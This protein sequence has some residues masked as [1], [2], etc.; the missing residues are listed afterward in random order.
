MRQLIAEYHLN[1]TFWCFNAN[2]GDTG[3][4][5]L[6]DFVTWD[7]DKYEFVRE[8]LWQ[9]A[10]GNFIGLDHVIALGD[11]GICLSDFSGLSAVPVVNSGA[12]ASSASGEGTVVTD[13]SGN[14]VVSETTVATGDTVKTT[15]SN[16]LK[17]VI[18]AAV[19][20]AV[21]VGGVAVYALGKKSVRKD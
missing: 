3:G 8:V 16:V 12:A 20:L 5:V 10:D 4:L 6:D 13:A 19:A 21:V 11:N 18:G 1:H 2:S 7:Q 17:I 9:D 14:V 15:L